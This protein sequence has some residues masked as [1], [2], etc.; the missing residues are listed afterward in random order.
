MKALTIRGV[1]E[2]LDAS[3]R[4]QADESGSSVNA[5]VL[6]ILRE[7]LGLSKRRFAVVHHDLDRFFGGWTKEE[8][9]AFDEATRPFSEIDEEMWR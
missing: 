9:E 5:T 7:H 3:L 6:R 4:Q 2:E 1:D 8:K